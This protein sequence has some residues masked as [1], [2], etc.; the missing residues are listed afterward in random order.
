MKK[1]LI[2]SLL[3][4]SPVF[5]CSSYEDCLALG[6][7]TDERN[8]CLELLGKKGAKD[9]KYIE[10]PCPNKVQLAIAYK[11]DDISKKLDNKSETPIR[12][13]YDDNDDKWEKHPLKKR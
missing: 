10:V 4:C 11:L 3:F 6:V 12:H 13:L 9:S 7:I 2:L 5:A 1:L 8:H